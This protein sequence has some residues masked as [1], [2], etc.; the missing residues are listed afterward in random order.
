VI[1][2]RRR[3]EIPLDGLAMGVVVQQLV[4]ADAAGVMMTIDPVNGDRERLYIESALGLGEGVVRGDVGV[5][6][7]WLAKE[8][9]ALTRQ[10][11]AVKERAHV[12]RTAGGGVELVDV[13]AERRAAPS[14]STEEALVVSEL[15]RRIEA[16][17]GRPMDIEWALDRERAVWMLQARPETVWSNRAEGPQLYRPD[18]DDPLDSQ[19]SPDLHWTRA[20]VGEAMPGVQT[21]LSWTLWAAG[22]EKAIREAAF[23]LGA[24]DRTERRVPPDRQDRAIRIFRGR[25]AMSVEFLTQLG[26]R[27]PGTTGA[28]TAQSVF[29]SV[30]ESI[31]YAP[32]WRRYPLIALRLPKTF[33]ATPAE[34]RCYA[35]DIDAWYPQAVT[36]I[37]GLDA[38]GARAQFAEAHERFIR[39]IELQTV[40]VLALIQ[41]LYQALT[42][43]VNRAG[44]GD[45]SVLSGSGGAEMA[46]VGDIWKAA[47]GR[48]DLDEVVLRHGFHG[49]MEGELSSKVWRDD[50]TPLERLLERYADHAD[51]NKADLRGELA[52]M[53]QA[54]LAALPAYQRPAARLVLGLAPSR[55][56]QR[57]IIKRSFL[58][59]L[60]VAR[61]SARRL[62]A[63]L[64][65]QGTLADPEDVFFLTVDELQSL[66]D[67][68]RAVVKKRRQLRDRHQ[69]IDLPG[70]WKG[71]PAPVDV[72]TP[73]GERAIDHIQ[74]IGVSAGTVEGIARV[75]TNPSFVDVEEGEILVASA[76]DPS[77]C[78]IMF[79]SA[80]LVVDIGGALSH[81][82]VVAREMG[83]PCVVST[84]DGSKRLR[85]GDR[86]RLDGATGRVDILERRD[87]APVTSGRS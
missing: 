84:G 6:R 21:P 48:L 45:V 18:P 85:T 16:T 5:D 60:D 38:P 28:A 49:P 59:C 58:Q 52:R 4:Q 81:A 31:E 57:G 55:I 22:A 53:R 61:A 42:D 12:Y 87:A 20:N 46:V 80:G 47:H 17:F 74:G 32:T 25:V 86:V 63:L 27:M 50:R 72:G 26:D 37:G 8:P 15:G 77:W 65:E 23:A 78:S 82:A 30:P 75:V 40:S 44:V 3:L 10:E 68:V 36:A 7:F 2:Y 13:H 62:G 43:L 66:P 73:E 56:Q 19:T 51:P 41:P 34:I 9:L 11:V 67:N 39:A 71:Q 14:L 70:A 64:A 54:V 1:A 76:T 29:G 69:A 35:A 33:I 24:L 83:I 79:I